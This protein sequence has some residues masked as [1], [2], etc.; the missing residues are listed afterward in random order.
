MNE[1]KLI[2][3]R[4]YIRIAF[5]ILL[6]VMFSLL[7]KIEVLAAGG[8]WEND[9]YNVILHNNDTI[10]EF[11]PEYQQKMGYNYGSKLFYK[12][13]WQGQYGSYMP[14]RA[15]E[16]NWFTAMKSMKENSTN[17]E[18][19]GGDH[20]VNVNDWNLKKGK[21]DP[22]RWGKDSYLGDGTGNFGGQEHRYLG[23]VK[24]GSIFDNPF[25]PEDTSSNTPPANKNW[26]TFGTPVAHQKRWYND[27]TRKINPNDPSSPSYAQYT[28]EKFFLTDI[29]KTFKAIS[30]DWKYWNQRLEILSDIKESAGVLKGY[31]KTASG[32]VYYQM[33]VVPGEADKNIWITKLELKEKD[34]GKLIGYMYREI[35]P[36]DPMNVDKMTRLESTNGGKSIPVVKIGKEYTVTATMKY[37]NLTNATSRDITNP[38]VVD[39]SLY[40]NTTPI[41]L[42]RFYK[43]DEKI[44]Q[45][46][47]YDVELTGVN[48]LE[49]YDNPTNIR[50][51]EEASFEW[52]LVVRDNV[53][54]EFLLQVKV[55]INFQENG[56]N[57]VR[58]DDWAQI[59][60][61]V[62]S[63]DL[64]MVEPVRL[65]NPDNQYVKGIKPKTLHRVEFNV[66][67]LLGDEA[68]GLHDTNN[69]KTTI[70]IEIKDKDGKV[71][72]KETLKAKDILNPKGVVS[73]TTGTFE[74]ESG[75]IVACATINAIHKEK[76]Y[77]NDDSNDR[78]CRA[79]SGDSIDIGMISPIKMYRNGVEV[80][81][82]E[83]GLPHTFKFYAHH[84]SGDAPVGLDAINNPKVKTKVTIL[85]GDDRG[86]E[87]IIQTNAVLYPNGTIEMPMTQSFTTNNGIIKVCVN[88]DRIHRDKGFDDDLSNNTICAVFQSAKNYSV[89]DVQ[90]TPK[91]VYLSEGQYSRT[92]PVTVNF[93]LSNEYFGDS[94]GLPANPWVVVKHNNIEIW[95]GRLSAPVGRDIQHSLSF[96]RTISSGTNTF[97]VEVNP[98]PRTEIESKPNVSNPYLDNIKTSS[99]LVK[100]Y[101]R[102]EECE[103][104]RINT[105][106]E[107]SERWDW[108]EQRGNVV[109]EI[110]SCCRKWEERIGERCIDWGYV[111]VIIN[112]GTPEEEE[113]ERFRCIET[114]Y[115][116]YFLC[117]EPYTAPLEYCQVTY[118]KQW[119]EIHDYYETFKIDAVYFTSKWS[120]DTKGG[121]I[122]V[123]GGGTGKIK[124]G[125]GFELSIPV[126]YRTNRNIAPPPN[127]YKGNPFAGGGCYNIGGGYCDYITRTPG[128]TP[129]DS[130][131]ILYMIMPYNNV[132]YIL[133]PSISGP[134]HNVTKTFELPLRDS[135]GIKSERKIYINETAR[136][137]TV[138]IDLV[139]PRP[140]AFY[141]YWPEAPVVNK[142]PT[143]YLHDCTHFYIQILPQDDLKSHITQ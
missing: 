13:F 26:L 72:R 68:I 94:L 125:Y 30:P 100:G 9:D 47:I 99:I 126:S 74:V 44:G 49:S 82:V 92:V 138:R 45:N 105:R 90:L 139:T 143:D 39:K 61:R 86:I 18:G 40:T 135:F 142:S 91:S 73:I 83:N 54:K 16:T 117:V 55:P 42:D 69:P 121:A 97:S 129:V 120:K 128:V 114:E 33:F 96:I 134:W 36:K 95:R 35:D 122:N 103:P 59:H 132:C 124:A 28:I 107:W 101:E 21:K 141:G 111:T 22:T 77:N 14:F 48:A 27:I 5:V 108:T 89:K 8:E 43:W 118:F 87:Q 31:H 52:G 24:D 123:K 81:H 34:T 84:Y 2:N 64:A 29:G 136:P 109:N 85:D 102:C 67:H 32:A 98:A 110:S 60:L 113:V 58:E 88:V 57:Y 23:Y 1:V 6:A 93:T 79:F 53:K 131:N 80:K 104:G 140:N 20:L 56:D 119:Y 12:E 137:Q 25:F 78:I 51:L 116:T 76:G 127:P 130:P 46:N 70:D 115:Y 112:R 19:S 71:I 37:L 15:G 3:N 4:K 62:E 65:I 10:L 11:T 41:K 133:T 17:K 7:P 50:N 106:N 66:N 38:N 63:R 75:G